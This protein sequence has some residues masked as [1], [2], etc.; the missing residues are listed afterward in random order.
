MGAAFVLDSREEGWREAHR[1]ITGGLGSDVVIDAGGNVQAMRLALDL[2]RT[3]GRCVIASVVDDDVPLPGLDLLLR[4]KEV[5][6]SVGHSAQVEF[7]KALQY[8]AEG[9]VDVTPIITGRI[10]LKDAVEKGFHSLASNRDEIK[11]LVTP[12]RDWVV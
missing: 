1:H 3:Q 5:V 9:R 12:H 10:H 4:E 8:L 11:V 6:G 2:T 7:R